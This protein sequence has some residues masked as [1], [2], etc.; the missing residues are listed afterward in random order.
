MIRRA[1]TSPL[2][3]FQLG[4]DWALALMVGVIFSGAERYFAGYSHAVHYI[5][6]VV[7]VALA[8]VVLARRGRASNGVRALVPY[9]TV[10][11]LYVVWGIF[12]SRDPSDAIGPGLNLVILNALL[13]TSVAAATRDRRGIRR[14]A[15]IVQAAVLANLAISLFELTHPLYITQLARTLSP[16]ATAFNSLRPAG[17]WANP[18]DAGVAMLFGFILSLYA[19]RPLAWAGRIGAIIGIFL[20]GSREAQY[21]L[22]ACITLYFVAR[23]ASSRGTDL[24]RLLRKAAVVILASA[25]GL[26]LLPG[27]ARL[28]GADTVISYSVTRFLDFGQQMQTP[29]DPSR[30]ATAIQYLDRYLGGPW[31]GNGLLT[32]QGSNTVLGAHNMYIMVLG[33]SGPIVLLLFLAAL[34]YGLIRQAFVRLTLQDR[35][36]HGLLWLVLISFAAISH[37]LFDSPFAILLAGVTFSIPDALVSQPVTLSGAQ[38]SRTA[39][40]SRAGFA[41]AR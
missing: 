14:L 8:F 26:G 11:L 33:E 17:L 32:F 24:H 41:G 6:D 2:D 10:L 40:K 16:T 5:F 1:R 37:N 20:T 22:I 36:I 34:V 21:P 23:I 3:R 15:G 7:L 35:V 31:Q 4:V 39:I 38:G 25:T 18:N 13:L 19:P 28:A 29:E 9:M 27:V 30:G 12:V